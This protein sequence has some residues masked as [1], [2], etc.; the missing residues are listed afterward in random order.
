MRLRSILGALFLMATLVQPSRVAAQDLDRDGLPDDLEQALL[1]RFLPT[2]VLSAGECD[3]RPAAFAPDVPDPLVERR[4]GTL[5][6]HV[7]PHPTPAGDPVEMEVKFFHLWGRDCGRPSHAL[8]VEHV[9][10]LVTAP[11]VE[12]P[13]EQWEARYWYAAAH[14]DTICDASSGAAATTLRATST[15]PFVYVS[16]GKHASYLDRG[17]CKWGCGSDECD[18]GTAL[19]RAEI[20]NLGERDAPLNG[21]RW[22]ASGRWALSSKLGLDFDAERRAALDGADPHRV[23]ALRLALRA[24][25]SPI[26]GGDTGL[27]ALVAAGEAAVAATEAA[28]Q[29]T[30][31]AL[32]ASGRAVGLALRKTTAGVARFLRLRRPD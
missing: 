20:I 21:A 23:T 17:H 24:W 29:A 14:E 7:R 31:T 2:F 26:L 25:Q 22:L 6:G 28:G 16:K 5:Y 8:D 19:P 4:D 27:D 1:E 11:S 13:L 15:G 30:A 18:T 10:A 3:G 12:A 32:A 9:S